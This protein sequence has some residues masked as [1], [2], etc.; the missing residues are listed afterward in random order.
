MSIGT[1]MTKS[2]LKSR[3]LTSVLTLSMG[4]VAACSASES[5]TAF[6]PQ[7]DAEQEPVSAILVP[8]TELDFN[9]KT[10]L[11]G[12]TITVFGPAVT[13]AVRP[14]EV[15]FIGIPFDN[16]DDFI[17]PASNLTDNGN[18]VD[19]LIPAGV[20]DGPIEIRNGRS[21]LLNATTFESFVSGPQQPAP[22]LN[23][24]ELAQAT[25]DLSILVEALTLTGLDATLSGP[26]PFTVFAPD[27][28]AFMALLM[29]LGFASLGDVPLPVLEEILLYHVA[30]GTQSRADLLAASPVMTLRVPSGSGLDTVVVTEP[31]GSLQINDS[32]VSTPDGVPASNGIVYIID[33]VL[34]AVA[35]SLVA[36]IPADG[37][38]DIFGG[39]TIC[40]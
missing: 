38:T 18:S 10:G 1:D 6:S 31:G 21:V 32:G 29:E 35:P 37:A 23:I 3:I 24:V 19:V 15:R 34:D 17:V 33:E 20:P 4:A 39:R 9:P 5:P 2:T 12:D 25:P 36:T 27:N 13:N 30:N 40:Y 8:D 16:R 28:A 22:L 11:A 7:V 26:G 14:L